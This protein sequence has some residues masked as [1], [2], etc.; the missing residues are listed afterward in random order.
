MKITFGWLC[1]SLRVIFLADG[2]YCMQGWGANKRSLQIFGFHLI[3]YFQGATGFGCSNFC[4]FFWCQT[5][6]FK[7]PPPALYLAEIHRTKIANNKPSELDMWLHNFCLM[8]PSLRTQRIV[9]PLFGPLWSWHLFNILLTK[10]RFSL[11]TTS[12]IPVFYFIVFFSLQVVYSAISKCCLSPS[13]GGRI[14]LRDILVE[15]SIQLALMDAYG[16]HGVRKKRHQ[17]VLASSP[18]RTWILRV[19]TRYHLNFFI[20]ICLILSSIA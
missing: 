8:P 18:N 12:N 1:W 3:P 9:P 20:Q 15:L 5:P 2:A 11:K 4:P 10:L 6:A 14:I 16:A 17:A 19:T 7:T 13:F